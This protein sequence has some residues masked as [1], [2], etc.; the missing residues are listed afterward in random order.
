LEQKYGKNFLHRQGRNIK[1]AYTK[2]IDKAFKDRIDDQHEVDGMSL[3][4]LESK[5]KRQAEIQKRNQLLE[6][7]IL[8]RSLDSATGEEKVDDLP[9]SPMNK[10]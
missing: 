4:L 1:Q 6:K 5:I 8:T 7:G 3:N 2:E 9:P 10:G